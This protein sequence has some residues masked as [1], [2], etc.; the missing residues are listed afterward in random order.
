MRRP[1]MVLT[2]G[3]GLLW[4]GL[5]ACGGE[6]V[7]PPPISDDPASDSTV[8]SIRVAP[9]E[10]TIGM[11]GT[12]FDVGATALAEDGSTVYGSTMNPERFTW[13]SSAPDVA[14]LSTKFDTPTGN[15]LPVVSGVGEG[16]ATIAATSGGL[17]G[18]MTVT[19]RDRA[20]V[21]WSAPLDWAEAEAG[22]PIGDVAIGPDGTIYVGADQGELNR[23]RWFALSPRGRH[24][25]PWTS[26]TRGSPRPLSA[27]TE[28]CMSAR[29]PSMA[30]SVV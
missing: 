27:K 6:T 21:A 19:V 14:R 17:T 25:R 13:S 11:L 3:C 1:R 28:P 5:G 23:S 16:T 8:D 9:A 26:P 15:D 7:T 18:T 22:V 29:I 30:P 4:M 10:R 24:S 20:A 12:Q 2:A